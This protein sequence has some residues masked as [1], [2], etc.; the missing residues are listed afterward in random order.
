ML[1]DHLAQSRNWIGGERVKLGARRLGMMR[2]MTEIREPMIRIPSPRRRAGRIAV[3]G[4]VVRQTEFTEESRYPYP[5][6]RPAEGRLSEYCVKR[7][8]YEESEPRVLL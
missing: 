4:K 2:M 8:D 7:T 6:A 1:K 3:V 5:D